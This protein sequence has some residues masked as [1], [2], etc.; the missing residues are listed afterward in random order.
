LGIKPS[1]RIKS[2]IYGSLKAA[3]F[4]ILAVSV[5]HDRIKYMA[6][7]LALNIVV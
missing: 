1:A 6:K 7:K 2:G 4:G 5:S 3:C